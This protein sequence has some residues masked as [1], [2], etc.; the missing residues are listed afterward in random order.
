MGDILKKRSF[1]VTK[2]RAK[3]V[4]PILRWIKEGAPHVRDRRLA[5]HLLDE[6]SG[7][8]EFKQLLLPKDEAD[9]LLYVMTE[10]P[11]GVDEGKQLKMDL[12][13]TVTVIT[14]PRMSQSKQILPSPS[15]KPAI[16]RPVLKTELTAEEKAERQETISSLGYKPK[17]DSVFNKILRER[18]ERG[19]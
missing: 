17:P 1:I 12:S 13:P 6:T 19:E 11:E 2:E 4:R 7:I 18:S 14:D 16:A 3:R 10:F 8:E 15:T 9:L 5:S